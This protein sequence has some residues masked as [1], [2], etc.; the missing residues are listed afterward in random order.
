MQ[1]KTGEGPRR[2]CAAEFTAMF[3][4]G[5]VPDFIAGMIAQ[6][7]GIDGYMARCKEWALRLKVPHW[8]DVH[9][10]GTISLDWD[11][12]HVATIERMLE[13]LATDE[14]RAIAR[15]AWVV[16]LCN[17]FGV[18]VGAADNADDSDAS[19]QACRVMRHEGLKAFMGE[20]YLSVIDWLL[21]VT[22]PLF[23]RLHL[24]QIA[25]LWKKTPDL[26][27]TAEHWQALLKLC[28]KAQQRMDKEHAE[29]HRRLRDGRHQ[30]RQL[31]AAVEKINKQ[32]GMLGSICASIRKA[33]QIAKV[34]AAP[35]HMHVQ[36]ELPVCK[37]GKRKRGEDGE[38]LPVQYKR[39]W[40][41]GCAGNWAQHA[42]LR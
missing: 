31:F 33:H 28:V 3:A 34:V 20:D 16:I 35:T 6:S 37:G 4:Y 10:A 14:E 38:L 30:Q 36:V 23:T 40:T 13:G 18:A 22:N 2:I 25:P 9:V 12:C 24:Q 11:S 15:E 32:E 8:T 41:S 29:Y 19:H 39:V 17:H 5:I 42:Y 1:T 7:G 21:G 27:C 26:H